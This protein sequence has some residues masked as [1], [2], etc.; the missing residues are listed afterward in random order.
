MKT[1]IR[2]TFGIS[3]AALL[4]LLAG[5]SKP[6]EKATVAVT[7][8]DGM[9]ISLGDKM[10]GHAPL[11]F[12]LNGGT[13]LFKFHAPGFERKWETVVLK[14]GEKRELPVRLEPETASVLVVTKPVG[15]Q[16]V[17]NGRVLGATPLVLEKVQ[18]GREYSGQLRMPGY[19][20]REVKWSVD[21]PRPKQVMID[22]DANIVKVEFLSS[23]AK[24]RLAVD[25]RVLGV[26]PYRGELTEGRYKVRFEL[27]G[28][29]PLEQTVSL[30]RGETFRAEYVLTPLPGG[31]SITSVPE[32]AAI[33]VDNRKRGVTPCVVQDLPA[34]IHEVRAEKD[35]FDPVTRKVEV[36]PGYK[37]E[38]RLVLLSS[39]GE[40]ELEVRP[41]GVT[42]MLDERTVGVTEAGGESAATKPIRLGGLPPGKHIVTVTHPR[43]RPQTRRIEIEI[44]KGKLVRPEPVDV[45]IANCEIKY[46]D[47]RVELGAL[48]EES[49]NT[50][51]FG[52]EPGIKYEV[53]RSDLEYVKRLDVNGEQKPAD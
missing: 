32:G 49:D 37:D 21:G 16:L 12:K 48:F 13:Y 10:L 53:K 43:A 33:F 19:S 29:S 51:F 41:A 17:M 6:P 52:P 28:Y 35:G 8:P 26:T 27:D 34:G 1:M 39:T 45:W 38:I 11:T 44:E 5:C 23:P 9:T 2:M 7:G 15:A 36:T 24:A 40:L 14:T 25:G 30:S 4:L 20:E 50:I 3:V 31:I 46:T 47:G 22:L 18:P 42:V